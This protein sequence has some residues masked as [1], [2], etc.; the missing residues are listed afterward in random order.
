[1]SNLYVNGSGHTAV[2][3]Q[4]VRKRLF[5]GLFYT[6]KIDTCIHHTNC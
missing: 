2:R 1:M 6:Q 5:R 4:F 3:K